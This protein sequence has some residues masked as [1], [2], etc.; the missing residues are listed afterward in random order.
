M[1]RLLE[2]FL[3]SFLSDYVSTSKET[4]DGNLKAFLSSTGVSLHD[5][6]F[7]ASRVE[8]SDFAVEKATASALEIKVPWS[9]LTTQSIEVRA[10]FTGYLKV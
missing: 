4:K 3:G 8:S 10:L 2:T 9:S 7:N 6:E 5:I 1:E